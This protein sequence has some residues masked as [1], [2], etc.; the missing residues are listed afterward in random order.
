MLHIAQLAAAHLQPSWCEAA[1]TTTFFRELRLEQQGVRHVA[2]VWKRLQH[3]NDTP[4]RWDIA[5]MLRVLTQTRW[6]DESDV[7]HT[8][9][10]VAK[11]VVALRDSGF[12]FG[13]AL[14]E[15]IDDKAGV[16]IPV[17]DDRLRWALLAGIAH[18]S[19]QDYHALV[20]L[21]QMLRSCRDLG[22]WWF[23]AATWQ[24]TAVGKGC[25]VSFAMLPW[26]WVE[27]GSTAQSPWDTVGVRDVE[28]TGLDAFETGGE[29]Y[30]HQE[31]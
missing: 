30:D 7:E 20:T 5:Q 6:Q 28:E 8:D 2:G 19:L 24:I 18:R 13:D 17:D 27:E 22:E 26:D 21:P 9:L 31:L 23:D 1:N 16:T 10:G 15:W 25:Q 3:D 14:S 11:F 12:L 4:A 29:D